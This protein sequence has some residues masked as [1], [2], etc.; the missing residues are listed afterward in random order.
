[1]PDSDTSPAP[2]S[3]PVVIPRAEHHVSRK[4]I[5]PAALKVL[6]ILQREGFTAYLVGGGV[7]DLLLGR[8]PK[9]F[10]IATDAGPQQVRRVFHNC[11]LIGRRFRLA[12]VYLMDELIEVSTF[13][14]ALTEEDAAEEEAGPHFAARDGLIVRDN[15]FGTPEED[16][17][18]RDFTINAL[19]YNLADF[20][21]IDYVGGMADIRARVIRSIGDPLRRYTEDPVR[22][23]RAV[24]FAAMLDCT[25]EPAT[26][27]ALFARRDQ[28]ALAAPAR[29]FEE[30]KKLLYCG[31]AEAVFDH[32]DRTG[33]FA[34]LFPELAKRQA[35][36][37]TETAWIR[38]VM[39][40]LDIWH[41]AGLG[42]TPELLLA[43]LF[44]RYHE[45]LAQAYQ[46]TG[47]PELAALDIAAR[48]HMQ[49]L[50]ARIMIPKALIMH[51]GQIMG[52]QPRLRR[53]SPK[54]ADRL[55]HRPCFHDAFIYFK[56]RAKFSGEYAQEL[57]WWEESGK[58]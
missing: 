50:C 7:R 14:A 55:R 29:L 51:I 9:D 41:R 54:H 40:Q 13:R 18:R 23:I 57:A 1:M 22:M 5:S 35:Q 20:S 52:L 46:S 39:R 42:M 30:I 27:D 44:G 4:N 53:P 8:H 24:R 19:F 15:V 34:I 10:D 26:Y 38:R 31:R 36:D 49:R 2:S 21:V 25:I 43:L 16:A 33:L 45:H 37:A 47:V 3:T 17:R 12:H 11:R 56:L 32:L 48:E 58:Q 6:A 28:L